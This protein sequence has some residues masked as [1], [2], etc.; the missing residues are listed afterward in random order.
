MR[1]GLRLSELDLA[2]ARSTLR[3]RLDFVASAG[4]LGRRL[5]LRDSLAQTAGFG[6]LTGSA[7]LAFELPLQNRTAHGQMLAAEN[8]LELANINAQDFALQVQDL[9]LRATHG[10]R[11]AARRAELGRREV[12]FAQ[13]NLDAERARFQAGRATNNDVLL[14]QQELKDAE[15][16]LL[17]TTVD[18]TE[19]EVALAALTAEV[20]DRYGVVLASP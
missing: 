13:Q 11:T 19:T 7:G 4:A 12:E 10:I 6:E 8:D 9:V 18:Q 5:A 16:R 1:L 20:L 3:P 14:R 17:R 15:T 2:T